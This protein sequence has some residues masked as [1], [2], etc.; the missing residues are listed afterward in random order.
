MACQQVYKTLQ[1]QRQEDI[2]RRMNPAD[3]ELEITKT[4]LNQRKKV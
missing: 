3:N 4:H 2:K 1:K